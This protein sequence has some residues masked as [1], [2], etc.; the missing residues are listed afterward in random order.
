MGKLNAMH[1]GLIAKQT[2]RGVE[3]DQ[4]RAS[5]YSRE[6]MGAR[7]QDQGANEMQPEKEKKS[8]L[9]SIHSALINCHIESEKWRTTELV[10]F[11]K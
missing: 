1:H 3:P 11:K 5:R 4:W 9:T 2:N 7:E 10:A 6:R 8:D